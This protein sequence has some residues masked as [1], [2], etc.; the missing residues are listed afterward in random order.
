[1]NLYKTV[2]KCIFVLSLASCTILIKNTRMFPRYR[3]IDPQIQPYV[4]E[5][6]SLAKQYKIEFKR[7]VSIGI[8]SINE[9]KVVGLTNFGFGFVEGDIDYL[10]WNT[11]SPLSKKALVFHE[12]G[13]AYCNRIHG[14]GDKGKYDDSEIIGSD[15]TGYYQDSCPIS[16]MHPF[17]IE[18]YCFTRHY[19]EYLD[20][21]FKNC[22][23]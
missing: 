18:D 4:D 19:Q 20:E 2:V 1:M 13:H 6:F 10:Y 16:I 5:W 3:E 17:I 14:Y 11:V 12:F 9:G 21:L 15:R 22:K 7:S 8:T 23:P